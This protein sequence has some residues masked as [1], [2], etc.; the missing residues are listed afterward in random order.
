MYLE[1]VLA[2]S[3]HSINANNCGYLKGSE[4][5]LQPIQILHW[6]ISLIQEVPSHPMQ[7]RLEIQ[8]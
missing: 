2:G 4:E 5:G 3:K 6:L 8:W 7:S 1:Q